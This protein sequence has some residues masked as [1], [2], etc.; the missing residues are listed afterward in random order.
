M[1]IYSSSIYWYEHV[2]V[3]LK[4]FK[5]MLAPGGKIILQILTDRILDFSFLKEM[6][7]DREFYRILD[8]GRS[9]SYRSLKGKDFWVRLFEKVGL[10]IDDVVPGLT[11]TQARIRN[12]LTDL[13]NKD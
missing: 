12:T 1:T 7:P 2:E 6:K 3:C 13:A 5:R 11:K 4:E 8:R 9:T 10:K